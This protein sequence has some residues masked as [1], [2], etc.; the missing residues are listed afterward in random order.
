MIE[1]IREE[2]MRIWKN[3]KK[4][5]K[6]NRRDNEMG[7]RRGRKINE[8]IRRTKGKKRKQRKAK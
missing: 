8:R 4:V 5:K 6:G 7:A 3:K 1:G 2:K